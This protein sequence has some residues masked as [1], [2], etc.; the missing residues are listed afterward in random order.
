MIDLYNRVF[1]LC[2]PTI[3]NKVSNRTKQYL[4]QFWHEYCSVT[5][6]EMKGAEDLNIVNILV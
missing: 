1:V 6:V 4:N 5:A 3:D 2:V